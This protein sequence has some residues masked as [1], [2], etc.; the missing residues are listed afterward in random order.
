M[1]RPSQDSR[2]KLFFTGC[3]VESN[4]RCI[5]AAH[6]H[7]TTMTT[8]SDFY[9]YLYSVH[10]VVSARFMQHPI[11]KI[12]LQ[13]GTVVTYNIDGLLAMSNEQ[14]DEEYTKQVGRK[15]WHL[16]REGYILQLA[17]IQAALRTF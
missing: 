13:C 6:K 15:A 4:R 16:T 1:P 2:G 3:I 17:S 5:F 10:P 9:D 11:I 7:T 12:T 14:L 8:P